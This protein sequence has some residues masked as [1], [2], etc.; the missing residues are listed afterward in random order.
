M[1]KCCIEKFSEKLKTTIAGAFYSLLHSLS[2]I[3]NRCENWE[4]ENS[5]LRKSKWVLEIWGGKWMKWKCRRKSKRRV[6]EGKVKEWKLKMVTYRFRSQ[7]QMARKLLFESLFKC[8][9][10]RKSIAIVAHDYKC[11][12]NSLNFNVKGKR[13]ITTT[14]DLSNSELHRLLYYVVLFSLSFFFFEKFS[15]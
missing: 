8:I 13:H 6:V 12:Q 10:K 5:C 7:E 15:I 4:T 2:N 1:R 14:L 11:I 3:C 9:S